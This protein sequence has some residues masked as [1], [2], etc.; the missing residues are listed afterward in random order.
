MRPAGLD[1]AEMPD[2]QSGLPHAAVQWTRARQSLRIH[3][4]WMEGSELSPLCSL[5]VG[6]VPANVCLSAPTEFLV[7]LHIARMSAVMNY[8]P[9]VAAAS[10]YFQTAIRT[11]FENAIDRRK[12]R[13]C[14]CMKLPR[15][16]RASSGEISYLDHAISRCGY[17]YSRIL[18]S[19][20]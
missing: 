11:I 18:F 8:S 1:Y 19:P 16:T 17:V 13:K 7:A 9:N 12:Q 6:Y 3:R 15:S 4:P 14:R 5:L 2:F 20:L 10:E